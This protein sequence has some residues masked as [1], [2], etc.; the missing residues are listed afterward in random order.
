MRPGIFNVL[1]SIEASVFDVLSLASLIAFIVASIV[2]SEHKFALSVSAALFV[3]TFQM[4]CILNG[5]IYIDLKT[6]KARRSENE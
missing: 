3:F 4:H 2:C 5:K 1:T 6:L